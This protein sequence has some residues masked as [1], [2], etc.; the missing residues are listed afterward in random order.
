MKRT[1]KLLPLTLSVFLLLNSENAKAQCQIFDDLSVTTVSESP[2]PVDGV[3]TS[4]SG[5]VVAVGMPNIALPSNPTEEQLLIIS[6]TNPMTEITSAH[7]ITNQST[8]LPSG[9][10]SFSNLSVSDNNLIIIYKSSS[11][12]WFVEKCILDICNWT[13]VSN[14]VNVTETTNLIDYNINES[15]QIVFLEGSTTISMPSTPEHGQYIILINE[16][17][18]GEIIFQQDFLY[19]SFNYPANTYNF[20]QFGLENTVTMIYDSFTGK[21]TISSSDC[22]EVQCNSNAG[23]MGSAFKSVCSGDNVNAPAEGIIVSTGDS[24]IYMLH[25]GTSSI[26][27]DYSTNGSFLN[28]GAYP[29]NVQLSISSVVGPP[30]SDGLPDLNSPCTDMVLPGCPVIFYDPISINHS[31]VCNEN[32]NTYDVNFSIMG[33]GPSSSG[34]GTYSVT[35]SFNGTVNPEQQYTIEGIAASSSYSITVLNDGKGCTAFITEEPI[36]CDNIENCTSTATMP[37]NNSIWVCDGQSGGSGTTTLNLDPGHVVCYFLH[38]SPTDLLG[39]IYDQNSNGLFS[40]PVSFSG[41]S[42]LFISAVVGPQD[43]GGCVNPATA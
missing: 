26:I 12:S 41:N 43:S 34:G 17:S 23:Q 30:G 6:A 14:V 16:Q 3:I 1:I 5:I 29:T 40:K 39:T 11:A 31:A 21:W 20:G 15:N 19:V 7:N 28:N 22:N 9:T 27:Y 35:G 25:D 36:F 13:Q 10:Y 8:T 37:T 38:D 24:H 18:D 42:P 2:A 4:E 32:T 33:G